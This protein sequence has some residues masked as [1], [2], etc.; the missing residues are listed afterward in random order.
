MP[1]PGSHWVYDPNRGGRAIPDAVRRRLEARL[2]SHAERR[3]GGRYRRLEVRF[4]GQ[5]CYLD[6]YV[7]PW[8][9]KVWPVSVGEESRDKALERLRATPVHLCRLRYFSD[10]DALSFAFYSYA[11]DRYEPSVFASGA[12]VGSPEEALELSAMFHLETA[13][14]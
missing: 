8:L 4:R 10:E 3:F 11:S 13:G 1:R 5:F 7:E 2:Q 6:L 12:W 14:P 9:P